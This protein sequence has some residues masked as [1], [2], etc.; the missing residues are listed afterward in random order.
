MSATNSPLRIFNIRLTGLPGVPYIMSNKQAADPMNKFAIQMKEITGKRKKTEAEH[1]KLAK[2]QFYSAFYTGKKDEP[3]VPANNLENVI[4]SGAKQIRKGP[5]A[6]A[7]VLV[8]SDGSLQYK[9]PRTI[10]GLY[11]DPK[12]VRKDLIPAQGKMTSSTRP[13]F[14]DWNV[15]FDVQVI[16]DVFDPSD[17]RQSLDLAGQMVGMGNWRPRHGRFT[18]TKFEELA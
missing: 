13:H 16:A 12:F 18:V 7:G 1:K 17:L 3:I 4:I 14:V 9:G 8:M 5:K 11:K 10:D 6:K 2:L 15:E